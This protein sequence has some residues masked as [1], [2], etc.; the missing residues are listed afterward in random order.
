[1]PKA[2]A[3]DSNQ[4]ANTGQVLSQIENKYW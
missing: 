3:N 2:S 1:L 4:Y